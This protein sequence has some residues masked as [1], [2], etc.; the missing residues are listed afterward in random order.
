MGFRWLAFEAEAY[1]PVDVAIHPFLP[2]KELS[3]LRFHATPRWKGC[4]CDTLAS[5]RVDLAAAR[6]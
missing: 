1:P 4:S 3:I 5:S 2:A 6:R